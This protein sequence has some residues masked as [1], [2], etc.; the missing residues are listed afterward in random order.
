MANAQIFNHIFNFF[1]N[2]GDA[3][4]SDIFSEKICGAKSALKRAASGGF[5]VNIPVFYIIIC[6]KFIWKFNIF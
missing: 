2:I 5:Y 3:S 1:D 4:P 6:V